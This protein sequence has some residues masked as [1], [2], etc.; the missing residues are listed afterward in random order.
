M[1]KASALAPPGHVVE[2][3]QGGRRVGAATKRP[4]PFFHVLRGGRRDDRP[5]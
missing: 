3:W 1:A 4:K 5:R 2:I